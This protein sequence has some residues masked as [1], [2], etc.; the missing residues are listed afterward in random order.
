MNFKL[1]C[2]DPINNYK[3][4]LIH[5]CAC[6]ND[7]SSIT[8]KRTITTTAHTSKWRMVGNMIEARTDATLTILKNRKVLIAGG[9]TSNFLR[10]TKLYDASTGN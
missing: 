6:W 9:G 2:E 8:T 5:K 7:K 4:Q 3:F 1:F 10:S